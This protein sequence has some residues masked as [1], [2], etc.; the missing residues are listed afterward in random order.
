MIYWIYKDKDG[1]VIATAMAANRN[2]YLIVTA[3]TAA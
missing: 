2:G 3:V 1:P